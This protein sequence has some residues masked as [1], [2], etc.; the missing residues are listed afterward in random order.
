[1]GFTFP[2]DARQK[3]GAVKVTADGNNFY[4]PTVIFSSDGITP[5]SISNPIAMKNASVNNEHVANTPIAWD[6]LKLFDFVNV[7]ATLSSG[8]FIKIDNNGQF[9]DLTVTFELEVASGVWMQWYDAYGIEY[10]FNASGNSRRV[11]G[12]IPP[13]AKYIRGRLKLKA[14]AAPING[15]QTIVQVQ[16]V[17]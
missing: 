2:T 12:G 10:S 15:T 8:L 11:Y 17:I 6:G 1:M 9:R 16:E 3:A 13:F 14:A 7:P 4:I 5:I